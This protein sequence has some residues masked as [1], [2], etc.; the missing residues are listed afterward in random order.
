MKRGAHVNA[1][2]QAANR[3]SVA[4]AF[5]QEAEVHRL[6]GDFSAAETA[7]RSSSQWGRD[8]QPGLALLRLAQGRADSAAATI[9]RAMGTPAAQLQ[10]TRLL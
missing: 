2:L 3:R 1:A 5:Y 9:R 7:Y 8:P 6:R 10:R 4:A